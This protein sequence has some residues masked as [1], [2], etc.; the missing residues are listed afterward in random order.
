LAATSESLLR[1]EREEPDL[2]VIDSFKAVYDLLGQS[3]AR[4]ILIYD[5]AV[6]MATWG[7]TTLLVGELSTCGAC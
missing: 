1:V 5:L 7:A 4:R 3:S 2:I 6:Q